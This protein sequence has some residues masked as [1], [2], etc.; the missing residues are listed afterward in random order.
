[1]NDLTC[2]IEGEAQ[3]GENWGAWEA[4][5]KAK[6]S[7]EGLRRLRLLI[8]TRPTIIKQPEFPVIYT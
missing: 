5:V 4:R 2:E 1:M 7:Q 6:I 3:E 8:G